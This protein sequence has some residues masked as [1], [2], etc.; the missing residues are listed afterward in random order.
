MIDAHTVNKI[1]QDEIDKSKDIRVTKALSKIQAR[2]TDSEENELNYMF[3]DYMSREIASA[4]RQRK[5]N[6]EMLRNMFD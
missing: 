1:I 5:R 4:A 6:E 3:E 2:I